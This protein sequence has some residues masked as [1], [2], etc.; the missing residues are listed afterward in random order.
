MF[1]CVCVRESKGKHTHTH[2]QIH[3]VPHFH[4]S[5]LATK[6]ILLC[7]RDWI[8]NE[9]RKNKNFSNTKALVI[10][11]NVYVHYL[12]Y[13]LWC[14]LSDVLSSNMW[15]ICC[16]ALCYVTAHPLAHKYE[17]DFDYCTQAP[18]YFRYIRR[19]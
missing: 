12:C 14:Y 4:I 19:V 8:L 10:C 6:Y 3:F 18:I 9:K 2:T 1:V 5:S 11:E 13:M 15:W 16:I 17:S 7:N